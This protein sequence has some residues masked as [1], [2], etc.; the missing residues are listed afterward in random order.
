[1]IGKVSKLDLSKRIAEKLRAE[2]HGPQ[3]GTNAYLKECR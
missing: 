3:N 2:E 1:L